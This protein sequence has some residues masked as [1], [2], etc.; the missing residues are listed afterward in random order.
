[1]WRM[2]KMDRMDC[3]YVLKGPGGYI[4]INMLWMSKEDRLDIVY[5]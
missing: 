4:N 1:M 3:M 5:V 2:V